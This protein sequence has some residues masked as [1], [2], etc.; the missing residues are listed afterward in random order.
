MK[1]LGI[2]IL[3]LISTLYANDTSST[4]NKINYFED[5]RGFAQLCVIDDKNCY[6]MSVTRIGQERTNVALGIMLGSTYAHNELSKIPKEV[7]KSDKKLM[8]L[9][10]NLGLLATHTE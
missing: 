3:L 7:L 5:A 2:S 9:Y 1:K 6:Q 10:L 4:E 8:R